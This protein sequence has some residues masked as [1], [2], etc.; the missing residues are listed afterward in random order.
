MNYIGFA[1][2]NEIPR[3]VNKTWLHY[4]NE[5][6]SKPLLFCLDNG[7]QA[8]GI[9]F[10]C[11]I[12]Q[13]EIVVVQGNVQECETW[14]RTLDANLADFVLDIGVESY[15]Y[16]IQVPKAKYVI[17]WLTIPEKGSF[18]DPNGVGGAMFPLLAHECT[19]VANHIGW[20]V[21]IKTSADSEEFF[22]YYSQWVMNNVVDCIGYNPSKDES[23]FYVYERQN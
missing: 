15:G 21:G 11:N 10:K 2:P 23:D 8:C 19:H 7:H 12:F 13:R 4:D 6:E 18:D 14:I 20:D 9:R 22:T 3:V 5:K 17:V 1:C 16:H